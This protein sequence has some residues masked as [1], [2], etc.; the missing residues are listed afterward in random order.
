[1]AVRAI[2]PEE[3]KRNMERDRDIVLLDVRTREEYGAQHIPGAVLIPL[4]EA[5]VFT[6]VV[7]KRF[8]DNQAVF[9]IYCRSGRRSGEAAQMLL[10]AGYKNVYNLGGIRDWPFATE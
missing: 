10:T 8:P 4:A 1:M 6:S 2:S 9:Y 7:A 3:A 5:A